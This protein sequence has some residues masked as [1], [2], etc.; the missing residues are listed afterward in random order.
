MYALPQWCRRLL[1]AVLLVFG[2]LL[3]VGATHAQDA[4]EVPYTPATDAPPVA[5]GA[6]GDK[7]LKMVT[8]LFGA[9]NKGIKAISNNAWGKDLAT[10]IA[11]VLL[12]LVVVW[13][14][15]KNLLLGKGLGGLMAEVFPAM[16][17]FGLALAAMSADLG[18]LISKS[19]DAITVNYLGPVKDGGALGIMANLSQHAFS[20]FDLE[21]LSYPG[22]LDIAGWVIVAF[23]YLAKLVAAVILLICAA[24]AAAAYLLAEISVAIACGLGPIFYVWAIWRPT[25]WI[26][27]S[28]LK[29]L[30]GAAMQKLMLSI[31]ASLVGSVI[32]AV[33]SELA[34]KLMNVTADFIAYGGILLIA[35]I[36]VH[37]MKAAPGMATML[38]SGHG[39]MSLHNWQAASQSARDG[40]QGV[41]SGANSAMGS[42]IGGAVDM[43]QAA[44]ANRG[45]GQQ[46]QGGSGSG[47]GSGSS[48]GGGSTPSR[49][50]TATQWAMH[51]A[52]T[53]A[54]AAG[55][56]MKGAIGAGKGGDRKTAPTLQFP[57]I[58]PPKKP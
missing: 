18:V 52:K 19:V 33:S 15:A 4:P 47:S 50:K 42:A 5:E 43:Y 45:Q 25:E 36:A 13:S 29:F 53:A 9:V 51:G 23:G 7:S 1:A 2:A 20:L 30:I 24:F 49:P 37:L 57:T 40:A 17:M 44:A 41:A 38:L 27:N 46:A 31:M 26:F 35:M 14:Y 54:G 11:V 28:W 55:S 12:A 21:P 39:G 32:A 34:P 16:I 8:A 10:K 6:L 56:L 3:V 22:S 58:V 48:S